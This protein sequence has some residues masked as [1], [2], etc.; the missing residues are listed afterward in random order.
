[1]ILMNGFVDYGLP[2]GRLDYWFGR[3]KYLNDHKS[4][5]VKEVEGITNSAGKRHKEKQCYAP[6]S[7]PRV[8]AFPQPRKLIRKELQRSQLLGETADNKQIFLVDCNARSNVLKEIGRLREIAFR[9][10][11]EGTQKSRDMDKYDFCYRHIVLWD[12]NDQEIVGAYR[13]GEAGKLVKGNNLEGLYTNRLFDYQPDFIELIPQ[14]IELG[15]S[16]VQPKYWGK[17]GLDYLWMGIGAYLSANPPIKY[18]FGA[19]SISND[20]PEAAKNEIIGCYQHYFQPADYHTLAVS[21]I[22]YSY[23]STVGAQYQGVDYKD[24]L[25]QLKKNLA[26]YQQ[27]VPTLYKQYADFCKSEGIRFI[28]FN[29]DPQFSYC[30]DS[31]ILVDMTFAKKKKRQRYIDVHK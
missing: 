19:V 31:L 9:A 21:K 10:V 25:K 27:Q 20:Y 15:R 22:P 4:S 17:R 18:L 6:Y 30:V 26:A 5:V 23:D 28:D 29:I 24:G 13:I 7:K 11:G 1:M 8:I 12:D 3:M 16:F 2:K 14:A